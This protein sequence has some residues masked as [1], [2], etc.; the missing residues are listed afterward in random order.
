MTPR[1]RLEDVVRRYRQLRCGRSVDALHVPALEVQ[2][3]E[4]LGVVGPNGSGKSTLLETM[5]LLSPPDAGR[6][7]LDGEDVWAEG[8]PLAA[9]RRCPMLLQR[10][11]LLKTSVLGNVM[12]GLRARGLGRAEA[13]RRAE[14]VLRLV[15]L[16]T[17][18]HRGHRELSGGERQRVALARLL[19]LEPDVLLLDEPTAHVDQANARLIEDLIRELHANRG[20]TVILASHYVSQAQALA[21]RVVTLIGGQLIPRLI[22]NLFTGTLRA[23]GDGGLAFHGDDGLLLS[24]PAHGIDDEG[25]RV[26]G[27]EKTSVEI[28]VDADRLEVFPATSEAAREL[29]GQIE[30]VQE[31]RGRCRL[32]VRLAA[33]QG[34]NAE[35]PMA[36][37]RQ[38]G[39]NLGMSVELEVGPNAV[40]VI[41]RGD[42]MGGE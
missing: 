28:A 14:A 1:Y 23:A 34:L 38:L 36:E 10:T 3:G 39:L 8:N 2:S 40:R 25:A 5:A 17:L 11:V 26:P 37:Y 20:M 22:D 42:G 6:I 24:V 9:R 16:D 33:G 31:R 21:D 19:V 12:Y 7:F 27:D 35:M 13:R 4:I 30:S 29:A 15:G 18:A 32:L 41:R